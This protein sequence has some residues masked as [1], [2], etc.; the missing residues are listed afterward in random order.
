MEFNNIAL[1]KRIKEE[2]Q[3]RGWKQ[4][5]L[6]AKAGVSDSYISSI[7]RGNSD[8]SVKYLVKI[9]NT[10]EISVDNVLYDELS[11]PGVSYKKIDE[12]I[13]DCE[14]WELKVLTD[15][16]Q[17]VRESLRKQRLMPIAHTED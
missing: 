8:F 11:A 1:G 17:S 16:L 2:R 4:A 5:D 10:F 12:I 15:C 3:S 9:L 7:E 14:P 13:K 6:A